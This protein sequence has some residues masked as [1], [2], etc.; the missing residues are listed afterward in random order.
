MNFNGFSENY[1][2]IMK[3]IAY[4]AYHKI[5]K[6]RAFTEIETIKRLWFNKQKKAKKNEEHH[7]DTSQFGVQ[8][9]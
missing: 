9:T 8:L 7:F 6:L 4:H 2:K 3:N 1:L 5:H